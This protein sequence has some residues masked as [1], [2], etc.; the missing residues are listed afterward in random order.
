MSLYQRK[1]SNI[2]WISI[3]GKNNKRIRE[4][5]STSNKIE[6][7]RYHD[8]RKTE[9]WR[10]SVFNE[11]R[12]RLW[13]EAALMYLNEK[14]GTK[15]YKNTLK[16]VKI[17]DTYLKGKYLDEINK[18]LI[19]H[20]IESRRNDYDKRFSEV[21]VKVASTTV[22]YTLSKLRTILNYACSKLKWIES[23]PKIKNIRTPKKI[24]FRPV[25]LT[26]DDAKL[27]LDNLD[28]HTKP[29][30]EFS[31]ATGLRKNNV[32]HLMWSQ[33]NFEQQSLCIPYN[34]SKNRKTFTIPLSDWALK[35]LKSQKGLYSK[36]VFVKDAPRQTNYKQYAWEKAIHISGLACTNYNTRR[37]SVSAGLNS[38][39]DD[40]K[41]KYDRVRWHD[42]RH[43][44]AKWHIESGTPLYIL[45]VL[46]GW[47]SIET[48]LRY[49]H[50]NSTYTKSFSNNI[51]P[52]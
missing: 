23:V 30:I 10:E 37:Q 45:K 44:W 47:D 31:F 7:Q 2:W 25:Y 8:I 17:L 15:C 34:V 11:K 48:V 20:I 28:P 6:A 29:I 22:N 21:K 18:E 12:R 3:V 5:T 40:T 36:Y 41:F 39:D 52:L 19:N 49:A 38:T 42:I 4:S 26:K 13:E 9:I 32:V 27:I 51:K 46:G 1:D 24:K 43:S 35:I 33:V 16:E 50:I 14:K